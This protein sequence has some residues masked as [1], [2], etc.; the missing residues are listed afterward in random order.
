MSEIKITPLDKFNQ[1][2]LDNVH[3]SDWKNPEPKKMYNAVVVG[4]GSAGL[5]SAAGIAGLGGDV[6]IVE[7]NL[8]GG[9]CLNVGCV[10]SKALIRSAKSIAEAKNSSEYGINVNG[11]IEADFPKVMERL[12]RLRAGISPNDSTK[13][14]TELGI[15]VFIGDAKF[16]GTDCI[17]VNGQKLNFH[18]AVVAAGARAY[19]PPIP[20]IENSN[21]LTNETIFNLTQLPERFLVLG[22]GPVG[23]EMAQTFAR[24]GSRVTIIEKSDRILSKDD[25]DASKLLMGVFKREGIDI[26]TDSSIVKIENRGDHS[27]AFVKN[28]DNIDEIPFDKILIGAGRQPNVENLGLEAA[29]V[30]YDV[31]KGVI[32][33]DLFRTSNPKIYAAGDIASPY[34][35]THAADAMARAVITNAFFFGKSKHSKLIIPWATYTGPEI[36]GAGINLAQ[37]KS[38]NINAEE[39]KIDLK[40]V[41]RAIL[42]SEDEGF[43]K[44]VH[45]KKGRILGAT[46][47]AAH[48]GDMIGELV[49]A[50]QYGISLGK[51]ASVIHP[52]PT[53]GEIIKKAGDAYRKK[54][55]SPKV[56]RI[57]RWMIR[58][59]K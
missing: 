28:Q 5:V 22:G 13:R 42:D 25:A 31:R 46:L 21:Y 27:L 1:E 4:A 59:K 52:Y 49:M 26:R 8:M 18:R 47:V 54:L 39:I 6:A 50:M 44:V 12:R 43:L 10:P 56:A 2:L 33:D 35:F 58:R 23:S 19:I 32:I 55:L 14:F 20:G 11:Y 34:K 16:C 3:P 51:I 45:D 53:Q 9:D 38:K 15:D 57:L 36:A 24:L 30:N 41:D 40:H 17:E 7:R 48:A 29:K 37:A